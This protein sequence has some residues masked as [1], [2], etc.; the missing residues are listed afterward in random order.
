[1]AQG[2]S[3]RHPHGQTDG[4]RPDGQAEAIINLAWLGSARSAPLRSGRSKFNSWQLSVTN[5]VVNGV[6]GTPSE[7]RSHVGLILSPLIAGNN[8]PH[9]AW[10]CKFSSGSTL[11]MLKWPRVQASARPRP[12]PRPARRPR[13]TWRRGESSRVPTIGGSFSFHFTL[14]CGKASGKWVRVI[15][16]FSASCPGW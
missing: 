11:A 9:L 15:E 1:M 16:C 7:V 8:F 6:L 4:R 2:Q 12:R 3:C 13:P 5:D 14:S 10:L